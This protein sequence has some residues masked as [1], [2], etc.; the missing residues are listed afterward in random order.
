MNAL[1]SRLRALRKGKRINQATLGKILGVS[2]V[3]VSGYENGTR[4]PDITSL[5]RL[6]DYFNVTV[7]YLINRNQFDVTNQT[8]I[9]I[10]ASDNLTDNDLNEIKS[11]IEFKKNQNLKNNNRT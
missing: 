11:F 5:I 6:A 10:F 7:D 4:E 3:S 9:M 2:K 8:P 1:G